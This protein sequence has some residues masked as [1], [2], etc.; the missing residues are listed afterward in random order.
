MVNDMNWS[1]TFR[2][3]LSLRR[4]SGIEYSLS[5]IADALVQLAQ[6]EAQRWERET[7]QK[8]L[9]RKAVISTFNLDAAEK[10]YA[11]RLERSGG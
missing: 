8:P 4:L 6:I 1:G 11:E 7:T 10:E 5:K 9:P 3:L 2:G